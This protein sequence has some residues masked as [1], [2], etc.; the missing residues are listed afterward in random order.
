MQKIKC[1]DCSQYH[2]GF[3][4]CPGIKPQALLE[5]Q[6]QRQYMK[7]VVVGDG[8]NPK[9]DHVKARWAALHAMTAERDKEM[10]RLKDE[11][12]YSYSYLQIKYDMPKWKVL[13]II[14]RMRAEKENAA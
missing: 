2:Q 14:K 12:G 3:H 1:D 9:G 10:L 5:L 13:K 7:Q 8:S 4:L 11:E 6:Y